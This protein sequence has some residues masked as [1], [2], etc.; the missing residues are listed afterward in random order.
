L[1]DKTEGQE[2]QAI[3]FDGEGVVIDTEGAWDRSQE[4]LL[5][6]RGLTY[7]R[8]R[9]KPLLTGRS[10]REG[11]AVIKAMYGLPD[12]PSVLENERRNAMCE[13]IEDE[14]D[15]VQGFL[16][17]FKEVRHAFHTSLATAMDTELFEV[18]DRKLGLRK[19]FDDQVVT[20]EDVNNVA[21]PMPDLFVKAAHVMDVAP[22]LCIV[23]EDAPYGIQAAK[24]A[25]MFAVALTTT[26]S[27]DF[28]Q[29][30][31]FV[32]GSF[33][34]IKEQIVQLPERL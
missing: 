29:E 9:L 2:Y 26:Y 12:D 24:R 10:A 16:S 27:P 32:A 30:A 19:L 34:E 3:V 4:I 6:R 31:D 13:V 21:K 11:I 20:L 28:F 5:A 14:L 22:A 7:D 25:G 18:V 23:I 1:R 33:A 8:N 17:F 15:F